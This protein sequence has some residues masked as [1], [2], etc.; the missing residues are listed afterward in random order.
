MN[1]LGELY[2]AEGKYAQAEALFSQAMDIRRRAAGLDG[3]T[4]VFMSNLAKTYGAQGKY[5]QAE[6]LY[7]QA[8][9]NLRRVLGPEPVLSKLENPADG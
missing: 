6:A 1:N 5:E 8:L 3:G 7:A 4:L 2:L 9:K